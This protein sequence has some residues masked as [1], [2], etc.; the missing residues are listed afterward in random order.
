[1]SGMGGRRRWWSRRWVV[2]ASVVLSAVLG[3]VV[4]VTAGGETASAQRGRGGTQIYMVQKRRPAK[5]TEEQLLRWARS[6]S[7][8]RLAETPEGEIR[9][10]KWRF[11]IIT[12]F[13]NPPDDREFHML[14]YDIHDVGQRRFISEMSMFIN[15]RT[16]R[17]Y[18]QQAR[19]DR[20]AFRP[21]RNY[22]MVI[23]I[24][25]QEVA[26]HRFALIGQEEARSGEVSF[27][28]EDT[29]DPSQRRGGSS[30]DTGGDGIERAAD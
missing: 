30:R 14:F 9:T 10:R 26:R 13:R 12:R 8:K 18:V 2:G 20:P 25:R 22:E 4:M 6:A 16:Q 7:T 29:R 21:N 24:R 19:L 28:D 27:T 15:D 1:M 17:T 5:M 23:T 3:A 11:E